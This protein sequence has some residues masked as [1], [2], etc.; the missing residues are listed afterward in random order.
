MTRA[1]TVEAETRTGPV[2]E[3]VAGFGALFAAFRRARRAKRGR[4][5]EPAF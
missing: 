2:I 5:G 1:T 4:G 3:E